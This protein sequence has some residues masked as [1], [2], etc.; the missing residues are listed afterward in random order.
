MLTSFFASNKEDK[1][2]QQYIYQELPLHFIWNK[3][4]KCGLHV[5]FVDQLIIYILSPQQPAN[6][7][8]LEHFLQWLEAPLVGKIYD[9]TKGLNILHFMPCV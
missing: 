5:N 9:H 6:I 4:Q 1:T 7:F 2:A 3:Q 8:I